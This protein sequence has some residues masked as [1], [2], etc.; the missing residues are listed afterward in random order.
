VLAE[1]SVSINEIVL[2]TLIANSIFDLCWSILISK[3]VDQQKFK[4]ELE[5][6]ALITIS[7]MNTAGPGLE[8]LNLE[9]EVNCSTNRA[10]ASCQG[11]ISPTLL[12]PKQSSYCAALFQQFLW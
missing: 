4:M 2:K 7:L 8:P 12:A 11:L 9:T 6:K 3:S 1:A 5:I 10:T